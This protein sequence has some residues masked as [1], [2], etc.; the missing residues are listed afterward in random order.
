MI[1]NNIIPGA[2]DGENDL[3]GAA[4]ALLPHPEA[5]G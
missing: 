5:A 2:Q 3:V 1:Y 4:T